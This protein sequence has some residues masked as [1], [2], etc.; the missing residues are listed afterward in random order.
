MRFSHLHL[1]GETEPTFVVKVGDQAV[2]VS[3]LI[4]NAPDTL[5]D[6]LERGPDEWARVREAVVAGGGARRPLDGAEYASAVNRPP[7]I[8]AVGLNYAAHSGELNLK[9][10]NTPTVFTLW[11]N[12]LAGHDRTA[13]WSRR[14][15]EAVDYEAEL[16]VIIGRPARDVTEDEALEHVFGYTVV[17]DISARNIQYSEAQWSRCKSL[18]GFTP[19]GPDV[20]TADEIA[21]PQDLHIW[22]TVDG[23]TMQD[24]STGQ[25]V[26]SVAKLIAH[27]SQGI[28]L[29]PGTLISTGSPG[30]SGFSRTPQVLLGDGTTVTVGIDGIGELTTRCRVTDGCGVTGGPQGR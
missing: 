5:Q 7:A 6:L 27:L 18:D 25:M 14:M 17:N 24:A 29:L 19:T 23:E 3:S 28:T 8:I 9:T 26:R 21:D 10:D 20:V 2:P 11:P 22:T 30:G 15:S 4:E 13:T 1:D 16:G 12:S